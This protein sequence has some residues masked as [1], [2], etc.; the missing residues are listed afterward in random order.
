MP[1]S[2]DRHTA[3][4]IILL[5]GMVY[6]GDSMEPVLLNEKVASGFAGAWSVGSERHKVYIT[7]CLLTC[8]YHSNSHL[9]IAITLTTS[10]SNRGPDTVCKQITYQSFLDF[11]LVNM[12]ARSHWE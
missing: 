6:A 11:R 10:S 8:C 4:L 3:L 12:V 1:L 2:Q 9:T 7:S 5:N